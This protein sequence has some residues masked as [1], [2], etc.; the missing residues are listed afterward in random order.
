MKT[1]GKLTLVGA[2]PGDPDLI[3]VKGLKAL[4]NA[5]VVLYDALVDTELLEYTQENA[6][7]VL[8][9]VSHD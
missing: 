5:D 8:V 9:G 6:E 4:S 3:S 7:K 1:I 2:G